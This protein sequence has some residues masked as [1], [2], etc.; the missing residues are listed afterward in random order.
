MT[1]NLS[2]SEK[3][4]A[5]AAARVFILP[6]YQE[7][8]SLVTVDVMAIGLPVILSDKINIARKIVAAGAGFVCKLESED[9]AARIDQLLMQPE[10]CKNMSRAGMTL[11]SESFTWKKCAETLLTAYEV[12]KKS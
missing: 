1:S 12:I 6:S 9:I 11:V 10:L 3:W 2:G 8:F 4:Q 7:N 5:M